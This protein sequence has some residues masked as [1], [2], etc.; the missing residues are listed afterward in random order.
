M[1]IE[2]WYRALVVISALRILLYLFDTNLFNVFDG[3]WEIVEF[4]NRQRSV[5]AL[6]VWIVDRTIWG[7]QAP[8][9]IGLEYHKKI[10]LEVSARKNCFIFKDVEVSWR[11]HRET[12]VLFSRTKNE[13]ILALVF[14]VSFGR[15]NN[16]YN[17]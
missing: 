8:S 15:M 1:N 7:D 3:D 10:V 14:G 16:A 5:Y 13:S 17:G 9:A 6:R 2:N 4:L 12:R 11:V